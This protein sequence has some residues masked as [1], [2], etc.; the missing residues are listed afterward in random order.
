MPKKSEAVKDDV[1]ERLRKLQGLY[2]Q[3][4]ITSEEYE[5]KRKE[6]LEDL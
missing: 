1:E 3:A 6:I 5:Q 4:L 2:E